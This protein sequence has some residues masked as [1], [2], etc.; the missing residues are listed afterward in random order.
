MA[1]TSTKLSDLFPYTSEDDGEGDVE[2]LNLT[3]DCISDSTIRTISTSSK[4]ENLLS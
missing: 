4:S 1:G 2:S 3:D